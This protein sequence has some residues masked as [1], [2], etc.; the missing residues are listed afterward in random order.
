MKSLK[1]DFKFPSD[2]KILVYGF[3]NPGRQ[4]DGLGYNFVKILEDLEISNVE[5]DFNYQ[6]NVED[7][8]TVSEYEIVVFVDASLR[9]EDE[10]T[11]DRLMPAEETR[12]TTHAISPQA[13][14]HLCQQI[15]HKTPES[16]LLEIKGY[17]WELDENLTPH[18]KAALIKAMDFFKNLFA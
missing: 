17:E 1:T 9:I 14:L 12:H 6:L 13:V 2:K 16:Y 4:D 15:Y 3:G 5:I 10:F 7:A 18:S 11:F 8:C